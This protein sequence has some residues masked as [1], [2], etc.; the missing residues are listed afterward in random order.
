MRN[1]Q[2]TCFKHKSLRFLLD[3]DRKPVYPIS[4]VMYGKEVCPDTGRKHLQ[5][6]AEFSK[7]MYMKGIKEL[8]KDEGLH[9]EKVRDM[10]ALIR[11][12]KKEGDFREYGEP[13]KGSLWTQLKS[14]SIVDIIDEDPNN[15]SKIKEMLVAKDVLANQRFEESEREWKDKYANIT[16]TPLQE[17]IKA[18]LLEQGDRQI[19]WIYDKRGNNGKSWLS[20]HIVATEDACIM[21]NGKSRDL[22]CYYNCESIVIFDFSRTVEGRINYQMIEDLKNGRVFDPKYKSRMKYKLGVKIVC[23]ANFEPD[24]E[25]MSLDRWDCRRVSGVI[26]KS[27]SPDDESSFSQSRESSSD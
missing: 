4:F 24:W 13:K 12:N 14:R 8:F 3:K 15:L 16:L 26:L 18:A 1:I 23:M 20:N 25:A 17:E 9:I 11:Y 22:A 27:H 2:F 21:V 6:Y 5:G 19:L 10:E 7:Q